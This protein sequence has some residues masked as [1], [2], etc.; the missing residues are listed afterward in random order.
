MNT[1]TVNVYVDGTASKIQSFSES[2]MKK[3]QRDERGTNAREVNAL[4]AWG[5]QRQVERSSANTPPNEMYP[6]SPVSHA[7]C[8]S[9]IHSGLLRQV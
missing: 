4:Q 9:F 7:A 6:P 1:G 3:G 8:P 5:E 2:W